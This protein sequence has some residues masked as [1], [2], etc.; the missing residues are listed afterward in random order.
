[1]FT[2]IIQGLAEVKSIS[3]IRSNNKSADTKLCITMGGKLKGDLKVGDSLSINGTCLTATRISKTIDFEIINETMNRTC[4]GLLKAGDKVNIERSL[5]LGDRLDGHLLLGHVD[6]IGIIKKIIKSPIQT[7]VWIRIQNK[8][9]MSCIVPKGS[10][11]I[12]GVSLTIIDIEDK[13]KLI[14][15]ALIP[16]TLA[17]TTFTLKSMGEKVNV[18]T[19]IIGKYLSRHLPLK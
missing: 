15:V 4:L 13:D 12:D 6:G 7:K 8:K 11:S 3:K 2:G 19:D 16:H 14:S 5:R 1:M 17:T 9:L 18:E 10:I